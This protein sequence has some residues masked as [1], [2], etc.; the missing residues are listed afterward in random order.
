MNEPLISVIVPVYKAEAY[1]E[2]C[3]RS[4]LGQTYRNLEII[5]IDDGS[6]DR[7]G[8]ICDM[9]AKED[10]RIQVFHKENGGQSSARNLGLDN[11]TGEYVGFVDSD[12][13]IEP[14]MYSCLYANLTEAKAQISC[15][16]IR[17]VHADGHSSYFNPD[18]PEDTE[19]RTYTTERALE[20]LLVNN[21]VTNSPCDKLF[22]KNIFSSL[23]MQVGRIYEDMEIMPKCIDQAERVVYDPTPFYCYEQ[24]KDSTMRAALNPRQ[25]AVVEFA[26]ARAK[27][28]AQKHPGL[29]QMAYAIYVAIALDMIHQARRVDTCAEQ[30]N[31][32]IKAMQHDIPRDIRKQLP[33]NTKVKLVV[34][35]LG[36]GIYEAMMDLYDRLSGAGC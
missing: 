21:K 2:K 34:L 22:S 13:W 14:D 35:Q 31:M 17:I 23:R 27:W 33:R 32:L 12:D 8:E 36:P 24:T 9:L 5:L 30:R 25:F 26:L 18:Y 1:L 4:I 15:C 11:M 7:C 16:G 6:P 20:E 3:V 10:S 19:L 28:F 29:Y